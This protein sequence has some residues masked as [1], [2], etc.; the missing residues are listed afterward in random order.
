MN[1]REIDCDKHGIA[2]TIMTD[3][4]LLRYECKFCLEDDEWLA[5]Q[6]DFN[7]RE[8]FYNTED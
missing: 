1:D 7:Y 8:T 3:S 6:N 5:K 2:E 4:I